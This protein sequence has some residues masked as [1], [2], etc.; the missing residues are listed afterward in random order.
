METKLAKVCN[1]YKTYNSNRDLQT[2]SFGIRV[3]GVNDPLWNQASG[4]RHGN[5]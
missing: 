4:K 1:M 3:E 2:N 5:R